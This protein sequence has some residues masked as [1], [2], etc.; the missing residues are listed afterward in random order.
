MFVLRAV[1]C[2]YGSLIYL[3]RASSIDSPNVYPAQG[4][5][6]LALGAGTYLRRRWRGAARPGQALGLLPA[7]LAEGM[8]RRRRYPFWW[9]ARWLSWRSS[10]ADYGGSPRVLSWLLGPDFPVIVA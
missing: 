4:C 9:L 5:K 8:P 3:C 6:Y 7:G 10:V 2:V 1:C